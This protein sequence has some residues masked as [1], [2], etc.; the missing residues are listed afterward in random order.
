MILI[1]GVIQKVRNNLF[2]VIWNPV[3][4]ASLCLLIWLILLQLVVPLRSFRHFVSNPVK[5]E[6]WFKAWLMPVGWYDM[7]WYSH[8]FGRISLP[9]VIIVKN[10]YNFCLGFLGISLYLHL[11]R[12]LIILSS[13]VTDLVM[14]D[15]SGDVCLYL[16]NLWVDR[17]TSSWKRGILF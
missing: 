4:S 17:G 6:R 16:E 10:E 2:R 8:I 1:V 5:K 7:I 15:R 12:Y 11:F 9:L 13:S 3:C 14:V